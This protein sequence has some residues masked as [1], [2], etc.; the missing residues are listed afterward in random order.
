MTIV[1]NLKDGGKIE[2]RISN[3][4][5]ETIYYQNHGTAITY[6][7]RQKQDIQFQMKIIFDENVEK[8]KEILVNIREDEEFFTYGKQLLD[9]KRERLMANFSSYRQEARRRMRQMEK[10][11]YK[12]TLPK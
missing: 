4:R 2:V 3:G 10:E 5:I 8:L 11:I 1:I 7:R 12:F 6:E 9:A